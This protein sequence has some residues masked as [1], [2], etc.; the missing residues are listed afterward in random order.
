M[1][2]FVSQSACRGRR[3][4]Q[5]AGYSGY[6][7]QELI[8][9]LLKER[10]VAR[11]VVAPCGYGK[12]WLAIDYAE[13]VFAWTHT[14]FVNCQ[15]ILPPAIVRHSEPSANIPSPSSARRRLAVCLYSDRSFF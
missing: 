2:G 14:F 9:R 5:F 15:R 12:T 4:S 11:F 6:Q 1:S 8:T 13:T 10:T 3:P 7:R